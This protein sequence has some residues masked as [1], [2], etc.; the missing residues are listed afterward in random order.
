MINNIIHRT[1]FT[2]CILVLLIVLFSL[3]INST[4]VFS[5]E[6]KKV[7]IPFDFVSKFDDGRYGQMVGDMIW[8][9]LDRQGGFVL[10]ES[11]QD[12]R[13]FCQSHN[14]HP[15]PDDSL[16][17]IKKIVQTDFGGDIVQ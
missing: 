16:D 13:D 2:P 17:K 9:K 10:P 14:M 6:Q 4:L 1:N 3:A 8:Q 12:V 15:L 11:M 7:V 5:E